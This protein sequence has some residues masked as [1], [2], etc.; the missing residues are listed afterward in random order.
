M[1]KVLDQLHQ[2]ESKLETLKKLYYSL[3]DEELDRKDD[4][5]IK[6]TDIRRQLL[7]LKRKQISPFN[8]IVK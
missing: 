7:N 6:L 4:C 2:L 8:T 1:E 3:P 5:L